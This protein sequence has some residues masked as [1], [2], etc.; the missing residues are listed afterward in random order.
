MIIDGGGY[1]NATSDKPVKEFHL[2]CIKLPR[3]LIYWNGQVN[4]VR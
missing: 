3:G 4:V 1:A 2:V